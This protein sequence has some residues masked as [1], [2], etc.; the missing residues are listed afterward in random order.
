MIPIDL[1]LDSIPA[2]GAIDADSIDLD[3]IPDLVVPID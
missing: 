3:A 1:L 2:L